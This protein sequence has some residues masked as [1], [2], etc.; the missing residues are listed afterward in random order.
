MTVGAGTTLTML[1]CSGCEAR[2]WLAD[3]EPVST[4]E[5]L[6]ITSGD[7]DFA[8]RPSPKAQRRRAG[9]AARSAR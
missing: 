4:D 7:P 3:G 1:S 9:G 2:T 8:V 5:V 6:K